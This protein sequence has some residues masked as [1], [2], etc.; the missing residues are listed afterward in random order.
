MQ[1]CKEIERII[2]IVRKMNCCK[3]QDYFFIENK[4][5]TYL[6]VHYYYQKYFELI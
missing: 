1:I 2:E 3:I 6:L 4:N 5:L